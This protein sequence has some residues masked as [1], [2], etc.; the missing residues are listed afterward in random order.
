MFS[1][2]SPLHSEF[3]STDCSTVACASSYVGGRQ[4]WTSYPVFEYNAPEFSLRVHL[5]VFVQ[6]RPTYVCTSHGPRHVPEYVQR[7][8]KCCC[9]WLCKWYVIQLHV[10]LPCESRLTVFAAVHTECLIYSLWFFVFSYIFQAQKYGGLWREGHK[11]TLECMAF[12]LICV[13]GC[14]P[15]VIIQWEAWEGTSD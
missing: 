15:A 9:W 7:G 10:C 8:C 12:T 6:G 4:H 14:R 1:Y 11:N 2:T 13:A 3:I 5:P